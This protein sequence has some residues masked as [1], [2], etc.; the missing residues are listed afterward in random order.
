M[1]STSIQSE[2]IWH[3]TRGAT[4]KIA[5]AEI[6]QVTDL[7]MQGMGLKVYRKGIGSRETFVPIR[8]QDYKGIVQEMLA[9]SRAKDG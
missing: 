5:S 2:D 1:V 8:L 6:Q 4:R 3:V 9:K 7:L